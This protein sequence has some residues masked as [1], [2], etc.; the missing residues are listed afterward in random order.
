MI[1]VGK[2]LYGLN[3]GYKWF[4]NSTGAAEFVKGHKPTDAAILIKGSRG[5]K[6]E[7]LLEA[8]KG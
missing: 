5:S 8:L 2:E 7:H 6:M 1:L 3:G 4:E